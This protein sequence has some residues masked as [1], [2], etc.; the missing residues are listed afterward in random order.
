[1]KSQD[2]ITNE[3]RSKELLWAVLA[4]TAYLEKAYFEQEELEK[5]LKGIVAVWGKFLEERENRELAILAYLTEV[6]HLKVKEAAAEMDMTL[7]A[8]RGK[9]ALFFSKVRR[10]A[11]YERMKDKI[12]EQE[13]RYKRED[14]IEAIDFSVRAYNILRRNHIK[15]VSQAEKLSRDDLLKMWSCGEKI[16]DEIIQKVKRYREEKE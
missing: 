6:K 8:F 4:R 7:S 3:E 2:F 11:S 15:T 5:Q 9:R 14:L 13:Q 10:R 1:M 16:A 12:L